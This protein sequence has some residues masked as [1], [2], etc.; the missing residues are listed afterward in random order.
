MS[1]QT[2]GL[3]SQSTESMGQESP[4]VQVQ[5]TEQTTAIQAETQQQET[6]SN[7]QSILQDRWQDKLQSEELRT[8]KSLA[9]FKDIENLAKGYINLEKKLGVPT[10]YF[11]ASDY[12][13]EIPE[14]SEHSAPI[15]DAVKNKAVEL[16]IEPS[17][18]NEL[19]QTYFS[20]EAEAVAALK[21][22]HE[23]NI[24]Q[25]KQQA[26]SL[27][28][29][30]WG[31]TF[32]DRMELADATWQ[33]F[34]PEEYDAMLNSLQPE[35]KNAIARVMAKIGESISSPTIGKQSGNALT[36]ESINNKIKELS[37]SEAYMRGEREVV[38]EVFNL[39]SQ[40]NTVG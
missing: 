34:A 31:D 27:L 26:T 37:D 15:M 36:R 38:D 33:R 17:K 39:Y 28:K 9:S 12:N 6:P 30:E 24:E 8:S 21:S 18:L 11:E 19:V 23:A 29:D 20:S 1:E 25:G 13:I 16:G 2:T 10:P 40:L 3:Q 32:N 4:Q 5:N 14:G 7:Q 35:H 22:Q